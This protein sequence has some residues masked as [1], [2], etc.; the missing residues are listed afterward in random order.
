[1]KKFLIQSQKMVYYETLVEA[2]HATCAILKLS[3]DESLL[4]KGKVIGEYGL[5]IISISEQGENT[6][7]E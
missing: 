7:K 2:D 1:M 4:E 6:I 3:E 5:K